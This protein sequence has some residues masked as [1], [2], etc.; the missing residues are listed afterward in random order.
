MVKCNLVDMFMVIVHLHLFV[1]VFYKLFGKQREIAF[2][3]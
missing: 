3:N 1:S 2:S